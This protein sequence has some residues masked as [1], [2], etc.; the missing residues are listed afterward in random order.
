MTGTNAEVSSL[1]HLLASTSGH[2]YPALRDL[3]NYVDTAK[4]LPDKVSFNT[5]NEI[6][7]ITFN[8]AESDQDIVSIYTK[9]I[10]FLLKYC[11]DPF[12]I[13]V[14]NM[15]P[16][17]IRTANEKTVRITKLLEEKWSAEPVLSKQAYTEVISFTQNSGGLE[18]LKFLN[19]ENYEPDI[20][21]SND[22]R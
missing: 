7:K 6:F 15:L 19:D 12:D 1:I 21:A 14:V 8:F 13:D 5:I 2:S 11:D 4:K 16:D 17:K 22:H 20:R 18:L 3:I 10:K 9:W